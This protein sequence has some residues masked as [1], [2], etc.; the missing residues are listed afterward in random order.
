[1]G[2]YKY[3]MV[4][5]AC[6]EIFYAIIDLL[7]KPEVITEGSYWF[8]STNSNRSILPL[9]IAYPL[10][11]IWAC[12]FG[13]A[14]ACFGVHF[15]FRYFIATGNQKWV[16]GIERVCLWL[17]FPLI[18]GGTYAL[19]IHLFLHLDPV[20]DKT[21]RIKI[22][23]SENIPTN[24][25]VYFGFNLYKTLEGSGEKVVDWNQIYE[26]IMLTSI[27]T[28]SFVTMIYF[29]SKLYSHIQIQR[30]ESTATSASSKN[31]QTQ[32]FYSLVIQ[33][34]IPI[35]LIHFPATGIFISAFMGTSKPIYGQIITV[36]IS[37]FPA[38]D[39]LPSLIII[40]PYRNAIKG[41]LKIRIRSKVES[42]A[43]SNSRVNTF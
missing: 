42:S 14:L 20:M 10:L 24:E 29:G 41:C 30:I 32:L 27:I 37:L 36:S 2:S 5:M 39:P 38:V 15:V 34:I 1:M 3:L 4:F 17:T 22:S 19:T 18:S 31:L 11:L 12:S 16:T 35:A 21:L 26:V 6:F 33:T 28:V 25:I 7:I 13:F 40:K 9:T 8:T 43:Q 23:E